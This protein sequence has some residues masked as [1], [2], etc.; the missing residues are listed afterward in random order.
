[1][2]V[3]QV[4]QNGQDKE[5]HNA[6]QDSLFIHEGGTASRRGPQREAETAYSR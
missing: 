5:D 6:G 2:A 3:L 1:M 4:E